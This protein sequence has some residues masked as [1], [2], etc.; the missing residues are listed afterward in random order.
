MI[1]TKDIQEALAEANQWSVDYAKRHDL[2]PTRGGGNP[3]EGAAVADAVLADLLGV[4]EEGLTSFINDMT[5][6]VIA[7]LVVRAMD[8]PKGLTRYLLGTLGSI[9]LAGL[10][11]GILLGRKFPKA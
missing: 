3:V 2:R 11:A 9:W 7:E 4:Q 8:S 10:T 5:A 1:T 6:P